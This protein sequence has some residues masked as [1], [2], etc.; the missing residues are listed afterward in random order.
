V[1]YLHNLQFKQDVPP[2]TISDWRDESPAGP[3][4]AFLQLITDLEIWL[5][6]SDD[7]LG[8][9][10]DIMQIRRPLDA[11]R[12]AIDSTAAADDEQTAPDLSQKVLSKPF[13]TYIYISVMS[14][15][16]RLCRM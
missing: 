14:H 9:L 10:G 12:E 5:Q 15:L 3:I 2:N 6:D 1:I 4:A 16:A 11:N 7:P 13:R 8:I